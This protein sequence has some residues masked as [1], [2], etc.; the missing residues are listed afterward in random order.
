MSL[1]FLDRQPL[2]ALLEQQQ[3]KSLAECV[4]LACESR[5]DPGRHGRLAQWQ[6]AWQ[7]LPDCPAEFD[8]SGDTV[9]VLPASANAGIN[10]DR[11]S[12][13]MTLMQFHPWRKGPFK[14]FDIEIDTEWR[15]WIKWNRL[16][17]HVDFRRKKV[18]DVGSGNG[19]YGWRM[20]GAGAS[21]VI[22]CEPFLLSLVQFEVF[23]KYWPDSE[24][25]FV[26]PL[27]DKDLP[28]DLTCFDLTLSMG[29]LYHSPNPIEH[30][31]ILHSTLRPRGQL[32]LETLVIDSPQ[33]DV[34][35]PEER[36]AK[37]RNTW[38]IPSVA[39]LERWLRRTRFT[40]IKLIDLSLTTQ[41]EQRRTA[42]MTFESLSDFLDP[43]DSSKTLEGYPAPQRAVILARRSEHR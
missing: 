31:Q 29:V 20:L 16:A 43:H 24:R 26:V 13:T 5:L 25:H 3:M 21:T 35:V 37:M 36:Y 1:R 30:L 14:I 34:L 28:K 2:L 9:R 19:Y 8:L 17:K 40:D 11:D 6:K 12:L 4:S 18:L 41:Q 7:D 39:M 23:R 32:V 10:V 42:W 33:C 22:G 27:A 15:S 38:F